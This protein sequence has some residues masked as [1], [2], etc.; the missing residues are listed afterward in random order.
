METRF[1]ERM[2]NT[3][4]LLN[5]FKWKMQKKFHF[6]NRHKLVNVES[7]DLNEDLITLI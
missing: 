3:H 2:Q 5:R 6:P 1:R 4:R 7:P